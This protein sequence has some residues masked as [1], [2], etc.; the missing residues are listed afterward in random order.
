MLISFKVQPC[1]VILHYSVKQNELNN[2]L[3]GKD[4]SVCDMWQKILA[5]GKKFFSII[6]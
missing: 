3:R 5:F 2:L 1:C 4:K 6:I